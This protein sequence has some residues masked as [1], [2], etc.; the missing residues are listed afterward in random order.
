MGRVLKAR[1]RRGTIGTSEKDVERV[2]LGWDNRRKGKRRT[3]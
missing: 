3:G 1:R 2:G